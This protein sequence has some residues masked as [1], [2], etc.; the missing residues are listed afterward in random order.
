M[1][2][3]V[4]SYFASTSYLV[5]QTMLLSSQWNLINISVSLGTLWEGERRQQLESPISW[6]IET[7]T[8]QYRTNP[9]ITYQMMGMRRGQA[10]DMDLEL[11][12]NQL[13]RDQSRF[14]LLD[15]GRRLR[16]FGADRHWG[17]NTSNA[18]FKAWF[19]IREP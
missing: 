11:V 6:T 9:Y 16:N 7:V 4:S 5:G 10:W 12:S 19:A 2:Q 8:N 1:Q 13:I 18:V 15:S 17:S 3:L 14:H